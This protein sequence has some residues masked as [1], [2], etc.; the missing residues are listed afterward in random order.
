M[1]TYNKCGDFHV[2][3]LSTAAFVFAF[4]RVHATVPKLSLSPLVVHFP[5]LVAGRNSN[6]EKGR[7][8][9]QIY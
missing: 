2:V 6:P 1:T 9:K 4:F 3:G 8:N 7:V 5:C